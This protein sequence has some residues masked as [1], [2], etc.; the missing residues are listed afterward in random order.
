MRLKQLLFVKHLHTLKPTS[1]FFSRAII[2]AQ[3]EIEAGP[4]LAVG[5]IW[6]E[7]NGE[8]M[9]SIFPLRSLH[10]AFSAYCRL[11]K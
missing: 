2:K 8:T 9:T 10:S 1:N 3:I 5:L 11:P 6:S 7:D 4:P